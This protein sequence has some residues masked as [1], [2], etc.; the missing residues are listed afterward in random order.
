MIV[1]E[2]V[3]YYSIRC[4]KCNGFFGDQEGNINKNTLSTH[5]IKEAGKEGWF[6]KDR[7]TLCP[8][9]QKRILE[10]CIESNLL[11]QFIIDKNK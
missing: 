7:I 11:D 6:I 1:T 3:T 8:I 5:V 4:E 9:C 2:T 10:Y